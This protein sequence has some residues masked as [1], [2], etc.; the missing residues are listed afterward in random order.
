[1]PWTVISITLFTGNALIIL[2]KTIQ[3][4]M[5]DNLFPEIK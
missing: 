4:L 5:F 2:F 3:I 1:M